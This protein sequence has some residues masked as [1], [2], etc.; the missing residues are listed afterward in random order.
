MVSAQKCDEITTIMAVLDNIMA[1]VSPTL[2]PLVPKNIKPKWGVFDELVEKKK[3]IDAETR[4]FDARVSTIMGWNVSDTTNGT[5]FAETDWSVAIEDTAGEYLEQ[6]DLF[7]SKRLGC[8]GL[9]LRNQCPVCKQ[10]LTVPHALLCGHVFCVNCCIS[11][12]SLEES[13]TE[14]TFTCGVCRAV[15]EGSVKLFL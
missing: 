1:L 6:L 13:S 14:E 7:L 2:P 15:S 11:L 8:S 4:A 3:L 10:R 12:V 9:L 5:K